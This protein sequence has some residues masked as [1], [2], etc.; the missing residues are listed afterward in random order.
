MSITKADLINHLNRKMGI[1]KKDCNLILECFFNEISEALARGEEVK[2]PGLGN[3]ST[4][5]KNS[6]PGRNPKT[7]EK[8]QIKAR[9]VVSFKAG[10]KLKEQ[11]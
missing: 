2:L 10:K 3:F 5:Y 1:P 4:S 7:G 11:L 9:N 6:R 8:F